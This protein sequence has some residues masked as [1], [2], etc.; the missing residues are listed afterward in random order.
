MRVVE[1]G[2]RMGYWSRAGLLHL[3]GCG[4]NGRDRRERKVDPS[5]LWR[6]LCGARTHL[7]VRRSADRRCHRRRQCRRIR[8]RGRRVG[9]RRSRWSI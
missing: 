6:V 2:D 3:L 1:R 9:L 5:G 8:G 4:K 7:R